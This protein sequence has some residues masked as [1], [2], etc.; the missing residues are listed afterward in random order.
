MWVKKSFIILGIIAAILAGIALCMVVFFS[1]TSDAELLENLFPAD[2]P[3]YSNLEIISSE[4]EGIYRIP[5]RIEII[6][7]IE[8]YPQTVSCPGEVFL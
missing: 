5:R 7:Q 3:G 1:I 2:F 8:S 4:G 6:V